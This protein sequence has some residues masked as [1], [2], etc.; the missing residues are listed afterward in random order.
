[1][2][3]RLTE[4]KAKLDAVNKAMESVDCEKLFSQERYCD[5]GPDKHEQED[6]SIPESIMGMY[7]SW[8]CEIDGVNIRDGQIRRFV[9]QHIYNET[10]YGMMGVDPEHWDAFYS[11]TVDPHIV[12]GLSSKNP[13]TIKELIDGIKP[14]LALLLDAGVSPDD[15][16]AAVQETLVE[17]IQA[18]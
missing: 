11:G 8:A 6:E 10:G 13:S 18:S 15:L 7:D 16:V 17:G 5:E 9:A 4:A 14:T 12:E 1:M 3:S 2:T